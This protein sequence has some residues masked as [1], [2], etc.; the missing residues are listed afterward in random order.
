[1]PGLADVARIRADTF[2]QVPTPELTLA[3]LT[4]LAEEIR[5]RIAEGDAGVVV[6]QGTNTIEETSFALDQGHFTC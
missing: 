5:R 2:R 4:A 6:T 1:M 3:D